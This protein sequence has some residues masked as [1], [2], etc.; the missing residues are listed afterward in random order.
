MKKLLLFAALISV[1]IFANAQSTTYKAFKVD[2]DFGY[3]IPS[4]GTGTKAG[5]TFTIEPH[6]RVADAFAIGLR[7]EGAAL[8]Y[9]N[10]ID[11]NAKISLLTS[12]CATGEYYF[13]KGGFRPFVG[14]GLGL[15]SQKAVS[16]NGGSGTTTTV[17]AS[18]TE[19]GAFP[20]IGFEAG[21]FR[22][23]ATYDA[24]GNNASYTSFTIGFFLGGGSKK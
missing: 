24:L 2:V 3:A 18:T 5:A 16:A 11:K 13:M 4:N 15:F 6:Y 21:H 8:G 23:A 7:L 14:G 19:F 22:M 9:E 1:S 20:R 17:R 10:Q 12:Y